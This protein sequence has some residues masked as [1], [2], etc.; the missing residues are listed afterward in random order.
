M[1]KQISDHIWY[2]PK[3]DRTNRPAL[4]Y[5]VSG[6]S[7]LM[8]DAGNSPDHISYFYGS[9]RSIG[10]PDPEFIVLTHWHWNHIFGLSGSPAKSVAHALTNE[11]LHIMQRWDWSDSS[12]NARVATGVE[13][14]SAAEMIKKEMPVR[15]S[16]KVKPADISFVVQCSIRIEELDC[17]LIHVGGP[18]SDDS[19]VVHVP[20][21]GVLFL[22]D[23][24]YENPYRNYSLKLSELQP[25]IQKLAEIDANWFL[26]A[27][28]GVIE[29]EKYMVLLQR[30]EEIGT[31]IDD[32]TEIDDGRNRLEAHYGRALLQEEID[33]ADQFVKGNGK[34]D[35]VPD[36]RGIS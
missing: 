28:S 14:A 35:G 21:E 9:A 23:C 15:H 29:K 18:H 19:I 31:V 8:L 27:H 12:L 3:D 13:T 30:I 32:A 16:F 24:C 6:R 4:G 33:L 2:L 26:P 20:Q 17:H 11:R 34:F 5:V 25:V 36:F 22:G 7:S 1:L 10:L